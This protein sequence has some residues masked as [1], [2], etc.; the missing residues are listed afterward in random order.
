MIKPNPFFLFF[1]SVVLGGTFAA[2]LI[3]L[4]GI[5]I[6]SFERFSVF[7]EKWTML[8][9]VWNATAGVVLFGAIRAIH[10]ALREHF[11]GSSSE[12]PPNPGAG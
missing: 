3:W 12:E 8:E 10:V 2:G 5:E 6:S 1:I 7:P 11:R 9:L 4:F